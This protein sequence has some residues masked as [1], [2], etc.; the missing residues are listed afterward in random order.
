MLL[1]EGLITQTQLKGLLKEQKK[2][3]EF[4]GDIVIRKRLVKEKDFLRILSRHF[5]IP[6]VSTR[7]KY[8]H[9]DLVRKFS[10]SVIFDYDCFPLRRDGA[11]V[12]F[13]ITNPLDAWALKK[14]ESETKGIETRFA[15][16]SRE[17]M[18]ELKERYRQHIK[19][20]II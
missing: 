8:I 2:T 19:D 15:L 16:I 7:Y 4:L 14:V 10:S 13:A 17:D 18:D 12:T 1:E 6:F 5:K 3:R 20:R 11:S 9:W